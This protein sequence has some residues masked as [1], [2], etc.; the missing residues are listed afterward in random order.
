MQRNKG[1]TLIELLVVIAII[2]ILAAIL[3]PVFAKVREKARQTACLSNI[4]QLGLALTQY[5]NDNDQQTP[6]MAPNGNPSAVSGWASRILP[7]VGTPSEYACPDDPTI[8]Q[9]HGQ[10][11]C[12]YGLNTDT[13]VTDQQENGNTWSQSVYTEPDKTVWLFEVVGAAGED[14]TNASTSNTGN[15]ANGINGD[16]EF[17]GQSA[18]GY[19]LGLTTGVQD[20]YGANP[21]NQAASTQTDGKSKYAG[22]QFGG[23]PPS[24]N[25]AATPRHTG[26]ANYLL[27]DGHAKW[28]RGAA[29]SGGEDNQVAGDPGAEAACP[30]HAGFNDGSKTAICAANTSA[31]GINNSYGATFSIH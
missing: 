2:A 9:V 16:W 8:T 24:N 7:Y 28:F 20:P 25:F 11:N 13:M 5:V 31:V 17:G 27:A 26:G 23:A 30:N 21:G 29:I 1:F 10:N 6:S 18:S 22:G 4:R 19:G 3:F 15:P 12:S 14:I